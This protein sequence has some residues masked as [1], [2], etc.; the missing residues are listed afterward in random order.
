MDASKMKNMIIIK[1]L[2]SNIV[3][4]AFIVLNSNKKIK[5]LEHIENDKTQSTG[6]KNNSKD[7]I[8]K[9][10]EM[11]IS[12]YLANIENNKKLK[13]HSMKQIEK[14]YKRLKILV[15]A[16]SILLFINTLGLMIA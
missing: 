3:D 4:E 14:K 2:P 8:T 10:A 9:E 13:S 11:I 5:A 15:V 16:I 12:N 6:S 1:N 7:Y